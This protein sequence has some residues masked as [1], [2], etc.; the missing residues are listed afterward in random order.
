[1]TSSSQSCIP[2]KPGMVTST[3]LAP[4]LSTAVTPAP[5]SACSITPSTITLMGSPQTSVAT[6]ITL[7]SI[8]GIGQLE[9]GR[10]QAGPRS[11]GAFVC[12]LL[13]GVL[14]MWRLRRPLRRRLPVLSALLITACTLVAAGCGS[15]ADPSLR[16]APAGNYQY[17]ITASST[18]GVQNS[19]TVTLNLIITN[20]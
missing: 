19:Q 2:A 20:R 8:R 15:G 10:G 17:L 18:S 5:Y 14:G 9:P 6:I 12:L 13:P 4:G 1:M 11:I 7:A 16:Y 3:R